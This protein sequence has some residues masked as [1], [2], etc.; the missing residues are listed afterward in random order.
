MV[1]SVAPVKALAIFG[2]LGCFR[3]YR[4][5]GEVR[6]LV[7]QDWWWSVVVLGIFPGIPLFCAVA[8]IRAC[9]F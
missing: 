7:D 3:V 2:F 8:P 6:G 9:V 1:Q 5:L 4:Y